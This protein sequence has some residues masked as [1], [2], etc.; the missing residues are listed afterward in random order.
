M[1]RNKFNSLKGKMTT[2][3][4]KNMIYINF[5]G[6][7][8]LLWDYNTIVKYGIPQTKRCKRHSAVASDYVDKQVIML[9]KDKAVMYKLNK[10]SNK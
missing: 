2:E 5:F 3:G 10:D 4:C 9:P 1:E 6:D 8:A 7:I